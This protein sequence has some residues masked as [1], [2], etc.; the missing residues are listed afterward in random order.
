[1]QREISP[2]PDLDPASSPAQLRPLPRAA[3]VALVHGSVGERSDERV[4][5][6]IAELFPSAELFTLARAGPLDPGLAR[7][8]SHSSWLHAIPAAPRWV[9][10][11]L[12]FMPKSLEAF[13]LSGFDLVISSSH[14]VAKG[15]RKPAGAVHVSYV[16]E[17]MDWLWRKLDES[18]GPPGLS[19]VSRSAVRAARDYLRRWDQQAS[20][21]GRIDQLIATSELVAA[22]I[23]YCY[24]REALVV[25]PFVEPACF[26][27]PERAREY[28][29]LLAAPARTE[30]VEL[31]LRAFERLGLPLWIVGS[32]RGAR[33]LQSMTR[34]RNVRWLSMASPDALATLYAGARAL[35]LPGMD[36]FSLVAVEAAASGL[37]VLAHAAGGVPETV[38][39]G[40]TGLLFRPCTAQALVGA[41]RA[42]EDGHVRFEPRRLRAHAHRFSKACFQRKFLAAVRRAWLDAGRDATQ[43]PTDLPH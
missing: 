41:V 31:T 19:L 28:Y 35:V 23:E 1:M 43:L 24:G 39:D 4:L 18:A 2:L 29:L 34:Q 42:L 32:E 11:L 9:H 7:R 36:E 13:D 15:I 17:P 16:H 12:P 40:V 14:G 22:H 33:R 26:A 30:H 20:S 21:P 10:R 8:I 37:P 25:H 6:A 27:R 5:A 3:R 38:V